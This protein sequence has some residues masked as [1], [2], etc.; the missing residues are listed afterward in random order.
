MAD[1]LKTWPGFMEPEKVR[2]IFNYKH[3]RFYFSLGRGLP[4]RMVGRMWFCHQGVLLGSFKIEQ[5]VVNDGS[6][7]PLKSLSG[8]RSAWQFKHD[9]KVAICVP[10]MEWLQQEVFHESFRGWRYFDF[11]TYAKTMEAKVRV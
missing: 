10:P 3:A 2:R 11:E 6:L 8:E 1:I 9:V 7:P 5:I 4:K